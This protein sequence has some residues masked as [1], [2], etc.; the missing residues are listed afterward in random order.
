MIASGEPPLAVQTTTVLP[1]VI[2][3]AGATASKRYFELFT[4]T[5]HNE[6][7]CSNYFHACRVFFERCEAR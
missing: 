1:L 5:I 4:V 7:T 6:H 3:A 2:A